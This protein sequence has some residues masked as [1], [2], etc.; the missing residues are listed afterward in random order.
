[1]PMIFVP[2]LASLDRRYKRMLKEPLQI[3]CY[4][5][6]PLI[7]YRWIFL[8]GLLAFCVLDTYFTTDLF[9]EDEAYYVPLPLE[10]RGNL[11][12]YWAASVGLYEKAVWSRT[13]WRKNYRTWAGDDLGYGAIEFDYHMPMPVL[14][15]SHLKFFCVGNK[16]EI[17]K[18]LQRITHIGKKR[19]YGYGE[20]KKWKVTV[21]NADHSELWN[22]T[23]VRPIP[24]TECKYQIVGEKAL[25][26][27]RPPYW[28]PEN[29][30]ECWLPGGVIVDVPI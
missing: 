15:I 1:M 6:T 23:L 4:L 14:S 12:W 27:Y 3:D 17:E 9:K 28:C 7:V 20:V 26:G 25:Y 16:R 19:A 8:D 22:N 21:I 30:T 11:H 10:R 29:F 2:K 13:V 5:A 18:L 24:I